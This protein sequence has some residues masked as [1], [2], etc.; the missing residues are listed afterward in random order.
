MLG[1]HKSRPYKSGIIFPY[2]LNKIKFDVLTL[3]PEMFAPLKESIIKRAVEDG[4]V[5]INVIDIRDFA[6]PPH[7]KCDDE[8][9]GGGAGMLMQ[10]QPVFDAYKALEKNMDNRKPRVLFMTPQGRRFDQ[11]FAEELSKEEDLI[12]LCGHYEGID[13]RI[14]EL[15]KPDEISIGDYVLT[16]GE[17]PSL[18][19]MDSIARLIPQ[20]KKAFDGTATLCVFSLYALT[21]L[22]VI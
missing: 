17:L 13:E 21:A 20:F 1:V 22:V 18:I 4:K 9:Y 5:E 6:L 2:S 11:K 7:F 16:G 3:F 14:I 15:L 10:A 12:F 19:M 8:P